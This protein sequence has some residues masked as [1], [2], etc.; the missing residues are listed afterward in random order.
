MTFYVCRVF[1]NFRYSCDR[2]DVCN[3]NLCCMQSYH[4]SPDSGGVSC[5]SLSADNVN[6]LTERMEYTRRK[7]WGIKEVGVGGEFLYARL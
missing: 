3:G 5:R 1:F 6:H 7:R 4:M 2:G